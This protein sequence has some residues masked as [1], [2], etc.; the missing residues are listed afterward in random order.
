[1]NIGPLASIVRESGVSYLGWQPLKSGCYMFE[2]GT[3]SE[4]LATCLYCWNEPK[5]K[6]AAPVVCW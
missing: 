2:Q 6:A 4:M 3:S 1:M 5:E